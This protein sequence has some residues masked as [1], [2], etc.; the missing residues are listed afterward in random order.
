MIPS[1][2]IWLEIFLNQSLR[3]A[4]IILLD[5]NAVRLSCII[6]FRY[7]GTLATVNISFAPDH[8]STIRLA[9]DNIG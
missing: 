9:L 1:L 2:K 4:K 3:E 8:G 5:K 7:L 6:T